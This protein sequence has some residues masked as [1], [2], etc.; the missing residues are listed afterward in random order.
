MLH[1]YYGNG[2]GKTTAAVGLA[3]RA[4]GQGLNVLFVQFLKSED[5]GERYLMREI[6][7]IDLTPCPLSID[8]TYN[9]TEPQKAQTGKVFKELFDNS[10][11]LALTRKYDMLILDEIFS[12]IQAGML[13][14]SQLAAFLAD[15]PKNLE[16][17]LTGHNPSKHILDMGDYVSH[18]IKER[19]PY[20]KGLNARKG[21]EF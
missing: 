2:K 1:I 13:T 17:V 19:H 18:I 8:F 10:V 5:T 3:I 7:N 9:M 4:A 14:E 11:K 6:E 20:D 16:I 15:A 12:A 21:I